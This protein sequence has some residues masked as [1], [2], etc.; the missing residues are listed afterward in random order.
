MTFTWSA[1]DLSTNLAKVRATIGDTNSD[2]Q[3]LSDE[4][5]NAW[6]TYYSDDVIKAAT[7]CVRDIIAQ[8]A[9]DFDRSATGFS[10]SRSQKINHYKMLLEELQRDSG[11]LAEMFVGGLSKDTEESFNDDE[12]YKGP[13]IAIGM[14]DYPG[15]NVS[16]E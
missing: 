5:I 15:S 3:L 1:T 14:D 11:L 10:G 2:N 8:L 13:S 9:R 6:L 7:R 12:D 4:H 16:E